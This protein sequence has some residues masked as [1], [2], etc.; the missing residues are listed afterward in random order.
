MN[1]RGKV[2]DTAQNDDQSGSSSPTSTQPKPSLPPN[3][4][5]DLKK[6]LKDIAQQL[7]NLDDKISWM[8][9]FITDHEYRLKELESMMNYDDLPN[10]DS[11][12]PPDSQ[13]NTSG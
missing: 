1:P 3:V 9:Y 13:Y 5:E 8:E 7:H 12:Y 10:N 2:Q 6:Q 4:I 11:S